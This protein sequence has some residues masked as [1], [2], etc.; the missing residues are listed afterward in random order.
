MSGAP[1]N[2][3]FDF[4]VEPSTDVLEMVLQS[5]S[6]TPDHIAVVSGTER[7]SYRHLMLMASHNAASLGE[8][9]LQA[10]ECLL[11]GVDAGVELPVVWLSAMMLGT[12]LIPID[13]S[14]PAAAKTATH[15]SRMNSHHST[16]STS[17]LITTAESR[18]RR[19]RLSEMVMTMQFA[20]GMPRGEFLFLSFN[21]S[22]LRIK[23]PRQWMPWQVNTL[24]IC[25]SGSHWQSCG[26]SASD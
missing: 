26:V 16:V 13:L 18:W 19:S 11:C 10:G 2:T 21:N 23:L 25:Q 6:T 15:V 1:L 20:H 5:H 12:V 14:W 9:G 3:A 17:S 4:D 24:P 22:H 7:V 8:A